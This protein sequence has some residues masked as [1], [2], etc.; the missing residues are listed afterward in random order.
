[1][2]SKKMQSEAATLV[3]F[4][5]S[6]GLK[7]QSV[8]VS[9][10]YPFTDYQTVTGITVGVEPVTYDKEKAEL[11]EIAA[12]KFKQAA[13][14]RWPER[15]TLVEGANG[16]VWVRSE[17]SMEHGRPSWSVVFG[18]SA[19]EQVQVG[20]KTVTKP[21]PEKA[22]ELQ[23]QIDELPTIEVEEP[24]MQWLCTGEMPEEV[25]RKLLAEAQELADADA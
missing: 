21:L 4:L 12:V 1:M 13:V 19:C 16:S 9:F 20:T 23:K 8:S 3:S 24:V 17:G 5:E 7:P 18:K 10:T 22:A 14:G 6:Q 15:R 11:N 25:E 2:D